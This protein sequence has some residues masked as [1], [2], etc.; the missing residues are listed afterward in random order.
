MANPNPET[1]HLK[2]FQFVKGQVANPA[3]RPKSNYLAKLREHEDE[4]LQKLYEQ[5]L[6]GNTKALIFYLEQLHGRATQRLE[7][8]GSIDWQQ[9]AARVLVVLQKHEKTA[10]ALRELQQF[11]LANS[12]LPATMQGAGNPASTGSGASAESGSPTGSQ[13]PLIDG[14]YRVE[15][16]PK[17]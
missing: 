5:C 13:A 15:I 17:K 6:R 11:F 3:G 12:P 16:E 2:Q 10:D 7:H 8:S 4:V 1:G 9:Q 14:E